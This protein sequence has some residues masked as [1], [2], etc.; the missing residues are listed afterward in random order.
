MKRIYCVVGILILA[1]LCF[2]SVAICGNLLINPGFEKADPCG[3][4][5]YG[6]SVYDTETYK[7][8]RQ[9]GKTWVWDCGDGLF[10]QFVDVTPGKKYR[11]S[12]YILSKSNDPIGNGTK[13]WIQIEWCTS[14]NIAV[15]D[16]IKS[17]ALT[18]PNDEWEL[19]STPEVIA[20]SHDVTRAKIKVIQ[21]APSANVNGAC[22]F[23]DADFSEVND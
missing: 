21:Q 19:F 4:G 3:W 10:E 14:D 1:V 5:A 8:G 20:P 13:A 11:A 16:P 17:L 9:S 2:S 22:Y 18:G 6:D 7:A 23:D 12:V 15:S